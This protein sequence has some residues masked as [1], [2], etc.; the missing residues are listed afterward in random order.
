MVNLTRPIN[1]WS[2]A[3]VRSQTPTSTGRLVF[4]C[5]NRKRIISG[6]I[7]Y[8]SCIKQSSKRLDPRHS[9]PT[10]GVD[11]GR[12]GTRGIIVFL[13]TCNL[14]CCLARL[15]IL[16]LPPTSFCVVAETPTYCSASGWCGLCGGLCG[17]MCACGCARVYVLSGLVGIV[18]I[19]G[20][21]IV[22]SVSCY[23][24]TRSLHP[25]MPNT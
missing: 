2:L 10:A 11:I 15:L 5:G 1:H 4:A 7:A 12:P 22:P 17:E 21:T 23:K 18:R 19:H 20:Q 14:R 24:C 8:Q 16:V 25:I 6:E 3:V 13:R 9:H